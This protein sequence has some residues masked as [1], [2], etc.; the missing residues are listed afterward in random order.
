MLNKLKISGI[1]DTLVV[2]LFGGFK[3]RS[4]QFIDSYSKSLNS[5]FDNLRLE[6]YNSKFKSAFHHLYAQKYNEYNWNTHVN[7]HT[8]ALKF[9]GVLKF[10]LILSSSHRELLHWKI[11]FDIKK[12][13]DSWRSVLPADLYFPPRPHWAK[14]YIYLCQAGARWGSFYDQ[15]VVS[16]VIKRYQTVKGGR[17]ALSSAR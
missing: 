5:I 9:S 8:F 1:L 13:C 7:N 2:V 4:G 17:L 10:P 12:R 14:I 11:F 15:V 3:L 6:F 16:N